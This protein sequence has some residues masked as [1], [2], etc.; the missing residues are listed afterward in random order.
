MEQVLTWLLAVLGL[1]M[2]ATIIRLLK[3]PGVPD[4]AVAFDLIAAHSVGFFVLLAMRLDDEN[5]LVGAAITLILGF[6]G[7]VMLARYL[8]S[9]F[10]QDEEVG[11]S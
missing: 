3:G 1:S 6:L 11:G 10:N 9:P 7:T 8:E 2:L 5:L 4:R